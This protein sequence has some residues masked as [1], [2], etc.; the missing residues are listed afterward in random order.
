MIV[1]KII[2]W[3]SLAVCVYIYFGYPLLL[4]V[5]SRFR[6]GSTA[7]DAARDVRCCTSAG[8]VAAS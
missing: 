5:V 1:A 3:I 2:F 7:S 8:P 4:W 6:C